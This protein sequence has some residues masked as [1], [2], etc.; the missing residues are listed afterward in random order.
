MSEEILSGVFEEIEKQEKSML[1][2]TICKL[3]L[4]TIN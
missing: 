1:K 4:I 3:A 2:K